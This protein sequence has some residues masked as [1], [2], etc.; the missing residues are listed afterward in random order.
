MDSHLL[1]SSAFAVFPSSPFPFC[2]L[3]HQMP[4]VKYEI[5]NVL[6]PWDNSPRSLQAPIV[7]IT[8]KLGTDLKGFAT[9]VRLP[10]E[11]P[12]KRTAETQRIQF[13]VKR[14][15]IVCHQ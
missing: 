13:R 11:T 2:P 10:V 9:K 8:S 7:N 3:D 12:T 4:I 6:L 15:N 1:L 14:D 5:I